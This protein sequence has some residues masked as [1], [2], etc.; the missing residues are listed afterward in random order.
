MKTNRFELQIKRQEAAASPRL[1]TR[2]KCPVCP[3]T[4][5]IVTR[6]QGIEIDY[7]PQC[8]GYWLDQ[9]ELAKVGQ[10]S[11]TPGCA[12]ERVGHHGCQQRNPWRNEP[13][14]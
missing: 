5:L 3:E 2:I 7:C 13:P 9:G 11:A 10:R 12:V 1:R 14:I 8:R 4:R 6:R